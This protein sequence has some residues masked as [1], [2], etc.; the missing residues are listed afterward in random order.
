MTKKPRI[1]IVGLDGATFDLLGP[2]MERGELPRLKGLLERSS[3]GRLLSTIPPISPPA[4][5]S[6]MTGVN[7]GK[8]G[9]YDFIAF[10]DHSFEKVLLNATHI[11]S[12]RFWDLAGRHGRKSTIL[13]LPLTYPPQPL[14]G[15]MISGNPVP[16]GARGI[17]P[18]EMAEE[19]D[20]KVGTW[21]LEVE[22]EQFR[23]F[24]PETFLERIGQSLEVRRKVGR[25]LLAGDWDLFVLV[26]TETD[27]V[28]H[29]LWEKKEECL[30]P[31]YRKVDEMVGDFTSFLGEDDFLL[32]LSDHGFGP[33]RKTFYLNTW[34]AA[35]GFLAVGPAEEAAGAGGAATAPERS[36][37]R[38]LLGGFRRQK[39][40]G[41][42]WDRTQAYFY[43][44]G[45]LH[46]I[47]INL[48]GREP[49]G[50]V[51]P[52]EYETVR[53]SVMES[54][55]GARDPENG[56]VV[57]EQIFRREDL[58]TGPHVEDAPDIVF[59]PNYEY[60]VS[61]RIRSRPFRKREDGRGV[62]RRDGIFLLKGAGIREGYPVEGA[63]LLDMAPTIL[64]LL[65]LPVPR[66]M[67]GRVLGEVFLPGVLEGRPVEYEEV[68]LEA[69]TD[70]FK[71][72]PAEEEEVKMRLRGLGYIE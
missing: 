39:R 22:G 2:W 49:G 53:K 19:L 52:G 33:V 56:K 14:D 3:H 62:H 7:P 40:K 57:V 27:M 70:G 58:Y 32:I 71:M 50:I 25:Y 26:L 5:A 1:L 12:R 15:V 36:L 21:W 72:A 13:H 17:Y 68:P 34:L 67:D 54:L 16:P 46:G 42:R 64:H 18:P 23:K 37:L 6:F 48:K 9:I 30:L 11:R 31:V 28:Q 8:H 55:A 41:I 43:N 59:V 38:R 44:T 29:L 10:K 65:G 35:K 47:G 60:M 20:A 4:W 24:D 61:D 51:P 63:T 69:E 45:Q 66:G